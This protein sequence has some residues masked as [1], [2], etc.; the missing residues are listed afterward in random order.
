MSK[1]QARFIIAFVVLSLL[2]LVSYHLTIGRQ[3]GPGVDLST[4][5]PPEGI[6]QR[7]LWEIAARQARYLE[8]AQVVIVDEPEVAVYLEDGSVI[9]LHGRE[10]RVQID[11]KRQVVHIELKGNLEMQVGEFLIRTQEAIF[12]DEQNTITST[13]PVE[14]SGPG[15]T[16]AGQGYMVDVANKLFVLNADVQTTISKREG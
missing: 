13:S 11:E 6:E 9:S 15:V 1:Q 16:V 7:M 4:F 8:E 10:A 5:Q 14:I 2:T 12:E 3:R